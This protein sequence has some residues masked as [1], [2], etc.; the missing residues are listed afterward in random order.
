MPEEDA[1]GDEE[2]AEAESEAGASAAAAG[3]RLHDK[4]GTKSYCAPE[5]ISCGDEG[6][7]VRHRTPT[8][9]P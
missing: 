4:I 2:S 6:Y 3:P 5:I 9:G 8:P 1:E 7:A